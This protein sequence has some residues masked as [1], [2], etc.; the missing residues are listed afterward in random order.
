MVYLQP[1][2]KFKVHTYIDTWIDTWSLA[3]HLVHI[4][5]FL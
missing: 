4:E 5:H 1:E 2:I 3:D